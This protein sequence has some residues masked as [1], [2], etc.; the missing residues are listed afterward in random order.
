MLLLLII[1]LNKVEKRLE[2]KEYQIQSLAL[3]VVFIFKICILNF[4]MMSLVHKVQQLQV[5]HC[6]IQKIYK[7]QTFS[8]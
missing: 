6:Q 2:L 5:L 8:F 1:F 7:K 4:C 3:K